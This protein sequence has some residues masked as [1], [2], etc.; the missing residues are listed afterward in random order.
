MTTF[1][2]L[3]RLFYSTWGSDFYSEH[4]LK[5]LNCWMF[6]MVKFIEAN[7][8]LE[9]DEKHVLT[10]FEEFAGSDLMFIYPD[11]TQ[12]QR[13]H[14]LFI[15]QYQ[16]VA[17]HLIFSQREM[18]CT[19]PVDPFKSLF[20]YVTMDKPAIK[21]QFIVDKISLNG[22]K[23][24]QQV[25][26]EPEMIEKEN[27]TIY[28]QFFMV[29]PDTK[30]SFHIENNTLCKKDFT[31]PAFGI[32]L[33][34]AQQL[35]VRPKY[36]QAS[37][38]EKIKA[39]WG[40]QKEAIPV[41]SAP[42]Q[43][44][45]SIYTKKHLE[46][47]LLGKRAAVF[48]Y[49]KEFYSLLRFQHLTP[50]ELQ[51]VFDDNIS[52]ED[53]SEFAQNDAKKIP[54]VN[55][56]EKIADFEF[57]VIILTCAL[58]FETEVEYFKVL[59]QLALKKN[60][61]VLSLYDDALQYDVFGGGEINEK[62][63]YRIG[64]PPQKDIPVTTLSP[65]E[66]AKNVLAVFGTDTVQ[67][68]FTTQLYLR[69]A[70]QKYMRVAHWATEPTGGLLGAEIGYSRIDESMSEKERVAF[71]RASMKA[72]AE[73]CDLVITGGQNSIIFAPQDGNKEDN[74]STL[75]FD[76]YLPR[77]IV[78]TVSVDTALKQVEDSI[79]YIAEL[80]AKHQITSR[81]VALAMMGGRKIRGARWTETYFAP[82]EAAT[83]ITA[84]QRLHDAFGL[85]L[86]LIP[87]EVDGLA[88]E[89]SM[90]DLQNG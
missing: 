20:V 21:P 32:P 82:V 2:E 22:G 14:D 73:S 83:V 4:W 64:L 8:D 77:Y 75:I 12:R 5:P 9:K 86:Y 26:L 18:T 65:E 25:S 16:A 38:H 61:P 13:V 90:I 30:F 1:P 37:L 84:K 19:Y 60:I 57:D 27:L 76:T 29:P 62:N 3:P 79:A 11:P 41:I 49:N 39:I 51:V 81:V 44:S 48:K 67:G 78:L 42:T 71:E 46:S 45:Q 80:A 24:L 33:Y 31:S 68:K 15:Q 43:H 55:D 34:V 70:L 74:V 88:K 87:D 40:Q 69:E 50:Y 89:I 56:I 28:Y 36:N 58:N 66:T 85:P 72:L 7:V 53:A 47:L 23:S 6:A 63:F 59:M 10:A 17:K 35:K 54:V 52:L